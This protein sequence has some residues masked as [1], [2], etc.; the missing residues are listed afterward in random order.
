MREQQ[1]PPNSPMRRVANLFPRIMR[2]PGMREAPQFIPTT[3][4]NTKASCH[5]AKVRPREFVV[6]C[7]KRFRPLESCFEEQLGPALEASGRMVGSKTLEFEI[8]VMQ[9]VLEDLVAGIV[10]QIGDECRVRADG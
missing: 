10:F 4:N 8:I 7:D 2:P 5:F 1:G 9:T 6:R 3:G